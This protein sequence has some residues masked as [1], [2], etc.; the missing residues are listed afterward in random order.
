MSILA[1]RGARMNGVINTIKKYALWFV[2]G[3]IIGSVL[4]A[5]LSERIHA[6]R[7]RD[8]EADYTARIA[9][10]ESRSR[11]L[12]ERT[13]ELESQLAASVQNAAELREQL[14]RSLGDTDQL[15]G[16][17]STSRRNAAELRNKF[18]ASQSEN[19]RLRTELTA[20]TDQLDG[21]IGAGCSVTERI[22]RI[23][24]LIRELS[25]GSGK[26]N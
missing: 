19:N 25:D 2:I 21:I 7:L 12:A 18:A 6:G 11:Q 4:V 16:Q 23:E 8:A 17:L 1:E 20:A 10:V 24:G 13:R 26:T 22:E 15:R 9:A 14:E 3:V 5:V